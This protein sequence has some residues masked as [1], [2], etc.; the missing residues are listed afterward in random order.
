MSGLFDLILVFIFII[1]PVVS[2]LIRAGQKRGQNRQGRQNPTGRS[3]AGQG[4]EAPPI[5]RE[6]A[7]AMPRQVQPQPQSASTSA[8]SSKAEFER[9]LAEARARVKESMETRETGRAQQ[10]ARS[11]APQV[12]QVPQARQAPQARQQTQPQASRPQASRPQVSRPQ[13][14]RPAPQPRSLEVLK[15]MGGQAATTRSLEG[16]FKRQS[17]ERQRV[18]Q[19]GNSQVDNSATSL[20]LASKKSRSKTPVQESDKLLGMDDKS[21]MRGLIWKQILDKPKSKKRISGVG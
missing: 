6:Q 16:S 18:G 21:I 7:P 3:E 2:N 13:A 1:L 20:I 19:F 8:D 17:L 4:S 12:Q 9:R 14:S 10:P 5:V 11:Q 15:P